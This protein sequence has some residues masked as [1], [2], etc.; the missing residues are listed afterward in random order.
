MAILDPA[1]HIARP[2]PGLRLLRAAT[3]RDIRASAEGLA[4]GQIVRAVRGAI[5]YDFRCTSGSCPTDDEPQFHHCGLLGKCVCGANTL[6]TGHRCEKCP[7]GCK[8]SSAG[9]LRACG[10]PNAA[11]HRS[12]TAITDN[13][14]CLPKGCGWFKAQG[15]PGSSPW[16]AHN[17]ALLGNC[18][19]SPNDQI[20]DGPITWTGSD[21]KKCKATPNA[22]TNL[23][24]KCDGK[25]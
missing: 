6:P 20:F 12:C 5:P 23:A 3:N 15:K 4:S 13:G 7:K 21:G 14:P 9:C 8:P 17:C 1:D 24:C 19:Q 16:V 11:V 2:P 25:T 22:M 10:P 18:V